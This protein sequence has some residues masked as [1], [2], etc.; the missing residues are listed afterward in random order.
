MT[1]VP[2]FT[3]GYEILGG[4]RKG[5]MVG[6]VASD[7]FPELIQTWEV[8]NGKAWCSGSL[9]ARAKERHLACPENG[10]WTWRNTKMR[11]ITQAEVDALN[12]AQYINTG[13]SVFRQYIP[14]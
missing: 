13:L 10:I 12:S 7:M 4:Q 6:C 5:F 9:H 14:G 2:K 1:N 3:S 8:E 11:R